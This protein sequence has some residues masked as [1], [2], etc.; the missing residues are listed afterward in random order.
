MV[1]SY[2]RILSRMKMKKTTTLS[3][4]DEAYDNTMSSERFKTINT[5][6]GCDLA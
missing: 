3:T 6:E 5:M 1:F 4:T 2:S